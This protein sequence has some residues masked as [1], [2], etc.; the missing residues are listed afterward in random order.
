[1]AK[2]LEH[3]EAQEGRPGQVAKYVVEKCFAPPLTAPI[4]HD[5]EN[6][7]Y[8]LRNKL[9]PENWVIRIRKP[10]APAVPSSPGK[11]VMEFTE[12]EAKLLYAL[13]GHHTT[14][15]VFYKLY[16]SFPVEWKAKCRAL[17]VIAS[18]LVRA[19]KDLGF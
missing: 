9:D 12:Y 11:V 2:V 8:V 6:A 14:G 4:F 18:G 16:S 10:A 7:R 5:L 3:V 19:P 15:E 13:L 1:M 17:E